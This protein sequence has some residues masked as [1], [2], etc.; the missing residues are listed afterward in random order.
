MLS[1]SDVPHDGAGKGSIQKSSSR[2]APSTSV[3]VSGDPQDSSKAG[4]NFK[5][6]SQ[7]KSSVGLN[8]LQL[9][10]VVP[11]RPPKGDPMK[12]LPVL[13]ENALTLSSTA[14]KPTC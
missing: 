3:N 2:V 14:N 4:W 11:P 5:A 12:V 7:S 10:I 8:R 9:P 13:L 6:Q 1:P